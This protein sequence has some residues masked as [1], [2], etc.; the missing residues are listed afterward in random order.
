MTLP[1]SPANGSHSL[2]LNK[3]LLTPSP[4]A[5]RLC[6]PVSLGFPGI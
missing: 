4:K 6:S 1:Q 3:V 5:L 2:D